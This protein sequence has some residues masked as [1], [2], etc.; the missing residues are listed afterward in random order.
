M[1]LSRRRLLQA[2]AVAGAAS[3][4]PE[5]AAARARR[6]A[7]PTSVGMLYDST[8]CIGCRTC[9]AKCREANELPPD[10]VR[11]EDVPYDAP[12]D[13]DGTTKTVIKVASAGDR[14]AFV[15]AQCMHCVDPACTSVCMIGALHKI[16]GT[17]IVAYDKDGCVGC[18]YCQVACPYNVPKFTWDRAV[19]QIVK[20]ELCRHRADAKRTGILAVAN[21]ACCEVCPRDAVVYGRRADLLE[22][23]R[24]RLAADPGRYEPGVFGERD[25]GG[26]QVL[27]LAPRG[28]PFRAMGLPELGDEPAPAL[29]ETIQHGLYWGMAAPVALFAIALARTRKSAAPHREEDEP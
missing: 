12:P 24:R 9:V 19:P 26:T 14:W 2:G 10:R 4:L 20:C 8:R 11:M 28:V 3:A 22:E 1:K 21:P 7:A 18:R 25:G 6:I 27:Y 16:A 13:L 5:R 29:S 17:G 15:K 23:A